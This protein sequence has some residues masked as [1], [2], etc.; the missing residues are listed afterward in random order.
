MAFNRIDYSARVPESAFEF[1]FP[2]NAVVFEFDLTDRGFT[3]EDLQKEMNF[4]L[5]TPREQPEGFKTRKIIKGR[6]CLPMACVIMEKDDRT[7]SLT[8]FRALGQDWIAQTGIP[9]EMGDC[10]G[11]LNLFGPFSSLSWIRGNT[12]MTLLG[13]IPYTELIATAKTVK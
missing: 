8:Q 9:V 10:M 4:E 5:L 1:E 12:A 2:P 13:N 7:I 11:Y 6:H 3:K